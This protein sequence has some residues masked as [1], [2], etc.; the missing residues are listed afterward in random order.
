MASNG[1]YS[2]PP[3]LASIL[4]TLASLTPQNQYQLQ[5]VAATA[6]SSSLD[7][8]NSYP[9][10]D[11]VKEHRSNHHQNLAPTLESFLPTAEQINST[12]LKKPVVAKNVVDPTCILDWP[13]GLRC[14][15]KTVAK[16]ESVLDEIRRLLKLQHEHEEQW[17]NGRNALIEKLKVRQEGQKKLDEVLNAVGGVVSAFHP[18]TNVNAM[19][20][21]LQT[22]DL[23]VYKAQMQMVRE[24]NAKLRSLGVPFF[25]TRSD[26][27]RP[28]SKKSEMTKDGDEM[29]DEADLVKLQRRMLE[30]LEDLCN[31]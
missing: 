28:A 22:F 25:G 27:V 12:S 2:N 20:R 5:P 29:I 6:S 21:E 11:L 19:E 15:M 24:M 26:L 30:M 18:D 16:H 23:K 14:V 13:A 9:H 10:Q 31:E 17:W 3:D 1:Y 4:K 7:Q 8:V